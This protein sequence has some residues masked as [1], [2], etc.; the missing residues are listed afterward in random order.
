MMKK[1]KRYEGSNNPFQPVLSNAFPNNRG[2][3]AIDV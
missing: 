2:A 3:T 1:E